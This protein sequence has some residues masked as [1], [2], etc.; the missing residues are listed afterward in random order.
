MQRCHTHCPEKPAK[1]PHLIASCLAEQWSL[2]LR[3]CHETTSSCHTAQC[4]TAE[5]QDES[6][7]VKGIKDQLRPVVVVEAT[8]ILEELRLH[9]L[10]RDSPES[11]GCNEAD[12]GLSS[13]SHGKKR[14]GG[15][16]ACKGGDCHGQHDLRGSSEVVCKNTRVDCT[17]RYDPA[18]VERE[19]RTKE[20]EVLHAD[21]WE[22]VNGEYATEQGPQDAE[23]AHK[24]P[25]DALLGEEESPGNLK[26]ASC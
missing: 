7:E 26:G 4:Y 11:P 5:T 20:P 25:H 23:H 6:C 8:G 12:D 17:G 21:L 13:G 19:G 16:D 14:C 1:P 2:D 3:S 22:L 9:E 24:C 18:S 10:R 15:S